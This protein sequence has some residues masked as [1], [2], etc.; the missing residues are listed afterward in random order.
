ME[1]ANPYGSAELLELAG[2]AGVI[3]LMIGVAAAL[4]F[5]RA[6][7]I[8]ASALEG[9][10][11]DEGARVDQAAIAADERSALARLTDGRLMIVRVMGADTSA[12]VI[13][14]DE[15]RLSAAGG[16][17]NVTFADLGYPALRM[18]IDG[19]SSWLASLAGK[20]AQP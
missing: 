3:L 4:G 5:R 12:R 1:F 14:R 7:R 19:E 17:L 20:E 9:F 6:A 10:A 18:P 13:A 15:V 16:W 11:R 2:S 8:D